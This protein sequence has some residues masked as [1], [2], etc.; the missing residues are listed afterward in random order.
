MIVLAGGGTLAI[1]G[2]ELP[3]GARRVSRLDPEAVRQVRAGEDALTFVM[4]D[5]P[6]DAPYVARGPF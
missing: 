6:G 1:A 3:L 5:A 4:V 2:E